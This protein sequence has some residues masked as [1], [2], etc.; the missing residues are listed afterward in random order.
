[1][2]GLSSSAAFET[3]IGTILSYMYNDGEV[4]PIEIAKIGQYAENIYFGKP[5]GLMDQMACSVGS[6]VHID[7]ADPENPIVEQVDF[8]MNAYGYSLCITDT[9]GSHA[10]LT[11]D[12]AAIPQENETGC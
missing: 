1:M 12:Y 7:F 6:L 3:L 9:K 10:D 8:D 11:P 5:C 2:Q 4:T